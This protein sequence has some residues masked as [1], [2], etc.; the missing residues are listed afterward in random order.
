[1]KTIELDT[2]KPWYKLFED[3][4]RQLIQDELNANG[5]RIWLA[6]ENLK[7]NRTT[8]HMKIRKLGIARR[9]DLRE[10]R[11]KEKKLYGKSKS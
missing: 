3:I 11:R 9:P 5:N 6:A 4:E 8:L 7:I 1:M 10:G 2:S